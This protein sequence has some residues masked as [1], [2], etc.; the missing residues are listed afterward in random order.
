VAGVGN[1]ETRDVAV[2]DLDDQRYD[3]VYNL[4]LRIEKVVP[5]TQSANLTVSADL[6]NVSNEDTVLQRFN[7]LERT[8]LAV[9]NT[10]DIKEIQSPRVWRFGLRLA[11]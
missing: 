10:N 3:N 6:F 11:F 4:D 7:R 8:G 2:S 1:S 5:I 9:G